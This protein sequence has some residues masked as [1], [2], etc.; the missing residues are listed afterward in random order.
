MKEEGRNGLTFGTSATPEL[1]LEANIHGWG[2]KVLAK[3]YKTIV[4]RTGLAKRGQFRVSRGS[5][6]SGAEGTKA[7]HALPTI[8]QV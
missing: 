3:S 8:G 5:T 7:D 2:I 1:H 4:K 6:S